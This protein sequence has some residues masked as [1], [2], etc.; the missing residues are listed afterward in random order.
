M[1]GFRFSALVARL[2]AATAGLVLP[3]AAWAQDAAAAAPAAVPVPDKGDTTWMLLSSVL[4]LLMIVP[5]LGLFY[6]GL[7]RAKNML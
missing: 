5:G 2:A 6:G 4:V 7:V 1:P 3:A